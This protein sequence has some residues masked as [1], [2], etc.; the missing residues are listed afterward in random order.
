MAEAMTQFSDSAESVK[1][2]GNDSDTGATIQTKPEQA[3]HPTMTI[4]ECQVETQKHIEA[5][6]KYIRF[7]KTLVEQESLLEEIGELNTEVANLVKEN[8]R[9]M[10]MKVSQLGLKP[11][12]SSVIEEDNKEE[13]PLTEGESR[14]YKCTLIDEQMKDY[15][16]KEYNYDI[17]L[18]EICDMFRNFACSRMGLFYEEKVI[19]LLFAG[20]AGLLYSLAGAMCSFA[21]MAL[22]KKTDKFSIIG[23]SL[24]GGIF[25]NRSP[26]TGQL[27]EKHG[28]AHIGAANDSH[29]RLSHVH[30]SLFHIQK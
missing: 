5:V 11:D 6:R 19:R 29:Q 22:L 12:E 30:H 3:A 24:A 28:F 13:T 10:A 18:S 20:F 7:R 8:E 2:V 26:M 4:P 27:I 9:I 14:F 1:S 16:P 25:H 15:V 23:V 21:V 17:T